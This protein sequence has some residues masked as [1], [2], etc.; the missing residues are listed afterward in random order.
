MAGSI[1]INYRREDSIGTAGRLHDRLAKAFGRSRLF[2]DVDHIPAGVDFVSHLQEQVGACEVFLA[3]I[4]PH[5]L[6]ARD[7]LGRGRLDNPEDFVAVEIAAALARDIRVIPVLID[8]ARMPSPEELPKGLKA[9]SYRNAVEVRNSQF[10]RDVDSLIQKIRG[11]T[12]AA[13]RSRAWAYPAAG[14]I[15]L[16]CAGMA[17]YEWGAPGW[18]SSGPV[19]SNVA[20]DANRPA[21]DPQAA[22]PGPRAEPRGNPQ[23][24][25]D[26]ARSVT[27]G[28]GQ[29][30]RDTLADGTP[31]PMCPEMVVVPQGRFTMGSPA[32]EPGRR[33]DEGPAHPVSIAQPFAIGKYLVTR[34]EFAAFASDTG[35]N[36]AGGCDVWNGTDWVTQR[37]RSWQSPGFDQDDRH[38]VV[39]VSWTDAKTLAAWLSAKTGRAY[40]LPSEAEWEYAARAG[41]ATPYFFGTDDRDFCRYGNGADLTLKK[42]Y[43]NYGAVLTCD[44]GYPFTAPVGSYLANAFGLYD[45]HGN[46]WEWVEDCYHDSLADAPSDGS[47]WVGSCTRR[48]VRGGAWASYPR[49]LRSATRFPNGQDLR[50]DQ[51]G[52]RL[53]RTV[54]P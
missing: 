41:T 31:C 17:L 6:D 44:D 25:P 27:A 38:P 30:F 53:A 26:P 24:R 1:F 40:R 3:L 42:K 21:D 50:R 22:A 45:M 47:A 23:A 12:K 33:T 51:W 28:S 32:G 20:V 15:L 18:I 11:A 5:W 29:S 37:E 35:H 52:I 49:S 54:S 34:A 19:R 43:P 36:P 10:G 9:L 2:M 46:A 39:C 7:A 48:V 13:P 14:L 4:G 16:V 8:G